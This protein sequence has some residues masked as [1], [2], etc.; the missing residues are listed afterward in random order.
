MVVLVVYFD[1][2]TDTHTNTQKKMTDFKAQNDTTMVKWHV[3][4][5]GYGKYAQISAKSIQRGFSCPIC[6]G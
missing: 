1:Q 4:T 2:H 3:C 5:T 6:G